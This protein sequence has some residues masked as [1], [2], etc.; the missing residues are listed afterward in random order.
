MLA[1]RFAAE[2]L[3]AF[4]FSRTAS[5]D[6][7]AAAN[8]LVD[9]YLWFL[10]EADLGSDLVDEIEL[11]YPKRI[12]VDAF[13]HVI[14]AEYRPDIRTFLVEAGTTLSQYHSDVG[15]RIQLGQ[16]TPHGRPRPTG[17][18]WLERR[19][20]N[21]LLAAAQDKVRLS[22]MFGRRTCH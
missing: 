17:T 11:P 4:I 5:P 15:N 3:D 2:L 14:A 20:E 12:L 10:K 9:G 19:L 18:Q 22:E 21:L 6:R 8:H 7:L 13:R 16:V 1:M